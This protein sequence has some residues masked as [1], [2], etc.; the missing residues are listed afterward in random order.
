MGGL[1]RGHW[2]TMKQFFG[3]FW[4]LHCSSLVD[5]P[6]KYKEE[7]YF[8]GVLRYLTDYPTMQETFALNFSY[9]VHWNIS[10]YVSKL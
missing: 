6:S 7:I 3:L 10:F 4:P 9:F 5:W 1:F 8:I 2:K